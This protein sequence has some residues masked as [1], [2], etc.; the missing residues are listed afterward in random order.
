VLGKG[1]FVLGIDFGGTKVALGTAGIDGRPLETGRIDTNAALGAQQA[2]ERAIATAHELM[3]RTPGHCAAVGAVSPGVI[4]PDSVQFAPNVPGWED[5]AL[6]TLIGEELG[7]ESVA[8][9]NDVK[10]AALAESCWGSLRGADPAVLLSLGTGVAAGI[11]VDG[12][13][14][15]GA[16]GAAGEI[17]YSLLSTRDEG[18]AANGRAPLEEVAGGRAIGERGSR[19]LGGTLTAAEVFAHPDERARAIVEGALAQLAVSVAN[20]AIVIDPARIAV[21]GGLMTSGDRVLAALD[22]RLRRAV[23]FPPELVR[24]HFLHDGALRGAIALAVEA[25]R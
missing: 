2:V 6:P 20:V 1:D 12:S 5:L 24:A 14:L 4:R 11:V 9:G 22:A 21:G 8:F 3:D 17:G 23:P 16:N 25:A 18:G 19:V 15:D 13:V 7:V 10:A